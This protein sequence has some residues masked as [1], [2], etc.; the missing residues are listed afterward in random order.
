MILPGSETWLSSSFFLY[1]FLVNFLFPMLSVA[2]NKLGNSGFYRFNDTKNG[3]YENFEPVEKGGL[4]DPR[5]AYE[6][7][8]LPQAGRQFSAPSS[9]GLDQKPTAQ[10]TAKK[11]RPWGEIPP[12]WDED[13]GGQTVDPRFDYPERVPFTANTERKNRTPGVLRD[14]SWVRPPAGDP[15]YPQEGRFDQGGRQPYSGSFPGLAGSVELGGIAPDDRHDD[16]RSPEDFPYDNRYD[17]PPRWGIDPAFGSPW[18]SWN[19]Q[20]PFGAF[21]W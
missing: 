6:D 19:R 18:D 13:N 2:E 4:G 15:L 8:P 7:V 3:S 1:V 14:R 21:G 12:E 10:S 17:L 20:G 11:T 9:Q 5:F 16:P